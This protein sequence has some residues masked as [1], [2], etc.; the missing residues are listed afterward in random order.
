MPC[1]RLF[2]RGKL[3]G[4]VLVAFS[5]RFH[6]LLVILVF[7][8]D[9]KARNYMFP[10]LPSSQD[11]VNEISP[12]QLGKRPSFVGPIPVGGKSVGDASLQECSSHSSPAFWNLSGCRYQ[13]FPDP[14]FLICMF[15]ISVV[16]IILLLAEVA[17]VLLDQLL[18]VQRVMS[19]N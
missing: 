5:I 11:S 18:T 17:T 16:P 15:M 10:R 3:G 13:L 1:V 7:C 9:W 19:E 6:L 8:T 14:W 12:A 2:L 4:Y